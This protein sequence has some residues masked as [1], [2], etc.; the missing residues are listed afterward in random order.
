MTRRR[1]T[2]PGSP[3]V[4]GRRARW[5]AHREA[6]RAEL[7]E[8]T[9]RAI[10][11]HGAAVGMD[12]IAAEAGTSKPV[13]YR[14]FADKADLYVAVGRHMAA[15][16]T[17]EISRELARDRDDPR[18]LVAAV[19]DAYL[20]IIE[21]EPEV[22]RFVVAR[23]LLDRPARQDPVADYSDLI[24]TSV[25]QV[26]GDRMRAANVDAGPAEPWGH[27]LVGLV[28]AAGDWWMERRPM[29][30]AALTEYLTALIWGG[31]AGVLAGAPQS[32]P[33][34]TPQATA[35]AR[36]AGADSRQ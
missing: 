24:A 25:A 12:Q 32:E 19:V 15:Q 36:P 17:D 20:R 34:G 4:D 33:Q 7:L 16:V 8:S 28:R 18:A 6:R 23:P 35:P 14:Y 2:A 9:V 1:T 22:Y 27:G 29:S 3:P 21:S 13:F 31:F 26:I 10:R 5:Q 30:R 11:R